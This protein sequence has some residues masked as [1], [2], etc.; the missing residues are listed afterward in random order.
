MDLKY[1]EDING[2]LRYI[3]LFTEVLHYLMAELIIE[4]LLYLLS[5][6]H[7]VSAGRRG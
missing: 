4:I 5:T 7:S 3:L 1:E 6:S 2:V